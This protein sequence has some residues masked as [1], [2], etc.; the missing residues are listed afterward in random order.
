MKNLSN[1]ILS[2]EDWLVNR[3]IYYAKARNYTKYTSTLKEA[4]RVSIASLTDTIIS[5]LHHYDSPLELEPDH[6]YA[7][8]PVAAYGILQAKKHRMRGVTLAMF[9][10]LF[11]CYRQSYLDLIIET[12]F[13]QKI[14]QYYLLFINRIFD[15]IEIGIC[16]EWAGENDNNNILGDLQEGNRLIVNEK[17][18]YLTLCESIPSPIFLLDKNNQIDYMN[19][20]ASV[21][22]NN[23]HTPGANYYNPKQV[24]EALPWLADELNC[25]AAGDK[26]QML[27]EKRLGTS[28]GIL[29]FE[30]KMKRMLDVSGKFTGTIIIMNDI[31]ER[32]RTEN[33]LQ[34]S[35]DELYRIFNTAG[36][37]MWIIDKDFNVLKVNA[38][39]TSLTGIKQEDAI[40]RKCY[41]VFSGSKCGTPECTLMRILSG[42]GTI[43]HEVM[44]R[45]RDGKLLK[46][47][48]TANPFHSPDGQLTGIVVDYKDISK[49]KQ[50]EENLFQ[51]KERLTITLNSIGDG[52]MAVNR[53]GRVTLLNP[54]AETLTGYSE[55][56]AL[57][58]PVEEVFEIVH[59]ETGEPVTNPVYKALD[60]GQIMALAN[61]TALIARSGTRTPIADSAAPIKDNTG[62][63]VGAILVFRDVTKQK[64][65]EKLLKKYQILFQSARDIILFVRT[66]G[67]II[68]ANEAAV[69][70][71]GYTKEEL[72]HTSIYDL[73]ADQNVSLINSQMEKARTSGIL[74]ETQHKRKDGSVFAVEV[75]SRGVVIGSEQVL[76]SIIR[77]I[78]ERKLAEEALC[79]SENMY[80][81]IFE[82][83]ASAKIIIEGDGTIS[84]A[85]KEFEKLSG[86][87]KAELEGTKKW[88]DFVKPDDLQR[89]YKYHIMRRVDPGSAPN[90]YE[91]KFVNRY[92][93]VKDILM[94]VDMI[95]ETNQSVASML[96]ITTR[97]ENE[98]K[99]AYVSLHDAL[100][101]LY[102]RSYFEQ[103][104][105][106]LEKEKISPVGIILCDVDGLKLFNDTL[107][108]KAG[109]KI[110]KSAAGVLKNSFRKEDIIARIGGDEFAVLL[111]HCTEQNI[112]NTISRIEKAIEKHNKYNQERHLSMSMGFAI[113]HEAE[114]NLNDLFKEADNNMY[115]QKLYHSQSSRSAIV[116]AL[117]KAL[118]AR[119]YIT[120][121]HADRLQTFVSRLAVEIGLPEHKI[122]SLR[123]LAQ[124]HDIGKVGI[125]DRILLKEGPLTPEEYTE[126]QRHCEI[127]YRIAQSAPDLNHI[128]DWILKHHEWWNGNGYPL[129]LKGEEIPLECRILAIADA[130]DAMTSDR[131]YRKAMTQG[132]ALKELKKCAGIQFDPELVDKFMLCINGKNCDRTFSS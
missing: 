7:G 123:L 116:N 56:E 47:I 36:D 89:M 78:T 63:I 68:E 80:R 120:E 50:V 66:D 75:S 64:Q 93:M 48:I 10:G 111:P 90:N 39:F 76:L 101:G 79:K 91:F 44:K 125:P 27:F 77:D 95:P 8:D 13:E 43:R 55:T 42:E 30:I 82:T 71:Y 53:E 88:M 25:F 96:N 81:A 14:A 131:P 74:F 113:S 46:L 11:K 104:M 86:Y 119:D 110:L 6:D 23:S 98:R 87:S 61:H 58:Q 9:L 52:V 18:K 109:D 72:L 107:G 45:R 112:K 54:V 103:E 94:S 34:A 118:E 132:E 105:Q 1:L 106:R 19:Y 29:F 5:V 73:R 31:T 59:E 57:G 3:L 69:Q 102:N 17:N 62:K 108:H 126:M 129:G 84:L 4:W 15:R 114:L 130:F 128:A 2:N 26:P 124:F 117:M 122:T 16:S 100:T 41:E 65:N 35:Y 33:L 115:R 83:T 60:T 85:N 99:L 24:P 21:L 49:R 51:E 38:T 127:G 70:A 12:K 22:F 32:K 28:E 20:F 37:G 97:K 121:G 67:L 40:G 92:G